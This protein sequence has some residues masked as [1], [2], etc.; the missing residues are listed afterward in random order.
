MNCNCRMFALGSLLLAVTTS[1]AFAILPKEPTALDAKAFQIPALRVVS[2]PQAPAMLGAVTAA[3]S[4]PVLSTLGAS[5]STAFLDS[6]SGRWTTLMLSQPL[7]PGSGAGN[8]LQ[9]SAL[10]VTG[11][12]A[13]A[14]IGNAA[15]QGLRSYLATHQDLL[16]IAADELGDNP[17]VGNQ[18]TGRLIQI[19]APREV[20]GVRVRDSYVTA[21]INHGNLVVLGFNRWGDI[22]VPTTP[23]R[24]AQDA[25][26]TLRGHLH[27]FAQTGRWREPRLE[28]VATVPDPGLA[29]LSTNPYHYRLVW[30]LS[31]E[32]AGS[33]GTWEA[34]ID[35]HSGEVLA[36]TDVNKYARRET[37]GGILP[38]SNDGL[39]PGGIPDGIE[40][41]AYPF[42]FL[43]L[44]DEDG[45][46]VTTNSSGVADITGPYSTE[47][48]GPFI[49]MDDTCGATLE[50]TVCPNLDLGTN[51]GTDCD[52]PADSDSLG[53][54]R[55][56]RTGF[57]ELNRLVE[58]ARGWIS[59]TDPANTLFFGTPYPASMNVADVCNASAGPT[60][61]NFYQS[62]VL[63]SNVCRN[64]GEIAAI[65]DHEWGH[66][67]DFLDGNGLSLSSETYGDSTGTLRLRSSCIGRGFFQ[68]N[69]RGGVCGGYGDVC[70]GSCSGVRDVDFQN[71]Q[72]G[73]PHNIDWILR[74]TTNPV[75]PPPGTAPGGCFDLGPGTGPC[76]LEE[77][78][79]GVPAA[80]AMWDTFNRDLRCLGKGWIE[81]VGGP[82]NGGICAGPDPAAT[83]SAGTAGEVMTRLFFLAKGNIGVW[84]TCGNPLGGGCAANSAFTQLIAADDDDGNLGNGTPHGAAIYAAFNRHQAACSTYSPNPLLPASC[85]ASP[86]PGAVTGLV[87]TPT[88][89]G[90]DLQWNDVPGA[91]QYWVFRTEGVHGC[92]FGKVRVAIVTTSQYT[93]TDQLAGF[94]SLYSVMAI[95]AGAG[96]PE[97]SCNGPLS[98]C[99][100][101]TPL[102]AAVGGA[103]AAIEA[104]PGA[105][106][107][108]TGDGDKF[109]DNCEFASMA[110]KVT[111]TGTGALS[112]VQL[113]SITL[114]NAPSGASVTIGTGLPLALTS[115][116]ANACGLPEGSVQGSFDFQ[117]QG[118]DP[119]DTLEFTL[120]VSATELGA[121]ITG[122]L[123][124][125]KTETSFALV[126]ERLFTFESDLEGWELHSGTFDRTDT[127]PPGAPPPDPPAPPSSWYL[128]SSQA[129]DTACDRIRSPEIV[130]TSGST[131][132][133]YN[134]F[135]TEDE[136]AVVNGEPGD[137]SYYDRGNVGLI[138]PLGQKIPIAPDSGRLYNATTHPNATYA[139]C[140]APHPGWGGTEEGVD[141][142]ISNFSASVLQAA[143]L[144]GQAIRIE[145]SSATDSTA[146]LA[147]VWYDSI[148]LTDILEEAADSGSDVCATGPAILSDIATTQENV[149]VVIDVLANDT[150]TGLSVTAVTQPTNGVVTNNGTNITYTPNNCFYGVDTFSYTATDAGNDSGTASVSVTVE[151][152]GGDCFF[153]VAPC[154][155][156]DSRAS[157]GALV[158]GTERS[159]TVGG[160][161]ACGVPVDASAVSL[162]ATIVNASG[163]GQLT[164]YPIAG[165]TPDTSTISFGP[166]QT[167][168]NNL[169]TAVAPTIGTIIGLLDIPGGGSAH[170]VVDVNGY[171]LP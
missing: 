158:S 47:L 55:S 121:P 104:V 1:A 116:L 93:A 50:T 71:H 165:E 139:G 163:L 108:L 56:S 77:H 57:F 162:N 79:E 99:V 80:E 12:P 59:A 11:A 127:P 143:G 48:K 94:E 107:I 120:Q 19:H 92:D 38:V 5:P 141:W 112:N 13:E 33:L 170:L 60:G 84:H 6:R 83:M 46:T 137:L 51:P 25:A 90:V 160:P 81:S 9:W 119:G 65:F 138:D 87:A 102:A 111:N 18:E 166:G 169:V 142:G 62:G 152:N 40:Q 31:P 156:Y 23:T 44:I 49:E 52:R 167:R 150:G 76:G 100:A 147:G 27:P 10:G 132:S 42:P 129:V 29:P 131:L 35:A 91:A 8:S 113:D 125:V 69:S 85:A 21:T 4:Q 105:L 159:I 146:S 154:R 148:K 64:T 155:L 78:C 24:S 72:S 86:R 45:N 118:L 61:M 123:R 28:L 135:T 88:I 164:I 124:V 114:T 75:P 22:D 97:G 41:P 171:F 37:V 161:S 134:R 145:L 34:L 136:G 130:L 14:A 2:T 103:A 30:V 70:V 110:F 68:A 63:G 98:G 128:Q 106:D 122:V 15:W 26:L 66:G 151:S 117:A 20:D 73:I 7:I 95:P 36:F 133:L 54:T 32:I 43:D 3:Q 74:G 58:T 96:G 16:G 17:S 144:A 82:I 89:H 67:L 53:N 101:V 115:L 153:A 168:A 109:L 157:G 39:A 140:N 126:G 149:A